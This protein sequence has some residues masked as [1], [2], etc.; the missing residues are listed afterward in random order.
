MLH[1]GLPEELRERAIELGLPQA[2]TWRELVDR[3]SD[4]VTAGR[5][6]GE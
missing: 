2:I 4:F 3:R 5:R 1:Y 6:R